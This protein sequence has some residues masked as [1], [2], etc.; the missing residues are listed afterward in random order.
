MDNKN[1]PGDTAGLSDYEQDALEKGTDF[2][3]AVGVR[4]LE[5]EIGYAKAEMDILPWH[6]NPLGIIH[7]GCLFT[8]ADTT[9]GAS[10][11]GRGGRVSTV[12]GSINYLKAGKNTTKIVAEAHEIKYGRTLSVCEAKIFNDKGELLATTSMTF[13]HMK[14]E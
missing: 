12:N 6:L 7:G 8:L 11:L 3:I 2:R 10:A 9:S 4:F 13:F 14:D 5:R 1:K